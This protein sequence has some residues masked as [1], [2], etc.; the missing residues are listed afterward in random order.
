MR[1]DWQEKK[2]RKKKHN[3]EQTD[4]HCGGSRIDGRRKYYILLQHRN[5]FGVVLLNA[6][7]GA[8]LSA[9]VIPALNSSAEM[10]TRIG[11]VRSVDRIFVT[12]A[13]WSGGEI[14]WGDN[15]HVVSV[16]QFGNLR[17]HKKLAMQNL[18]IELLVGVEK[19]VRFQH[20]SLCFIE[21]REMV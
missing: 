17:T 11:V 12:D 21:K 14:M 6:K 8:G 7:S 4:G 1:L 3:N 5:Y 19:Y 2:R 10:K 16:E 15:L 9:I 13:L 20:G 18:D